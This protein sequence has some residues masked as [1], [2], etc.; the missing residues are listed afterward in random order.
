MKEVFQSYEHYSMWIKKN[1]NHNTTDLDK[2][3]IADGLLIVNNDH[4]KK[5]HRIITK[6]E[7]NEM[8]SNG[9]IFVPTAE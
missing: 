3:I 7:F 6:N 1:W 5:I 4:P 8:E 9:F 2:K